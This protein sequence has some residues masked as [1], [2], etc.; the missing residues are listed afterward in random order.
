M[1]DSSWMPPAPDGVGST[2]DGGAPRL[3]TPTPVPPPPIADAPVAMSEPLPTPVLP[4]PAMPTPAPTGSPWS[5]TA[6]HVG[7]GSDSSSAGD[8]IPTISVEPP[9]KP[10]R[11]KVLVGGAVVAVLAVGTAGIFAV[12][13]IS[14]GAEGG[15]ATPDE[16]GAAL[17]TAFENEDAL[18]VI[19][20]L[21]PGERDLLRQPAIDLVG[22]LTRL[23]VLSPE[24]DLAGIAG[25]DVVLENE[26]VDIE[27][28]N[29]DDIVNV[30]MIA[31]AT[32]TL[33]GAAIPVGALVTDNMDADDVAEMRD[34]SETEES[35][36]DFEMTAVQ[37]DGRWYF[38]L[39]HTVAEVAR[40]ELGPDTLIP[41]E[42]IG[43]MGADTP[44][45]AME[46]MFDSIEALDVELLIQTLNPGE[47]AAL[48][49]Y[50]PL[51]LDDAEAALAEVPLDWQI[52]TREFRVEGDG[53]RR[54]V[55]V[56]AIGIDG[57]IDGDTFSVAV[58]GDCVTATMA[59]E[60]F[61][62]CA[63]DATAGNAE[64][65]DEMLADAP[66]VRAF[67][68]ALT[69]AFSDVEPL[70]LELREYDGG[71]YV[72]PVSTM[73]EAVL[74]VLRALDRAEIDNLI[75]LGEAAFSEGT[76]MVFG[77]LGIGDAGSFDDMVADDLSG[78]WSEFDDLSQD[79]TMLDDLSGEMT[80]A[81]TTAS[82]AWE[83]CYDETD[84]TT[85]IGCFQTYV[86]SG[87]IEPTF[88][89]IEL[90]FPECGY[91]DV[92]WTGAVYQMT[93]AEFIAAAE[94]ARPCFLALVE[95]GT[96]SEFEL[97]NEIAH[98]ECFE[99]RNWYT[100]FDDTAYDDRYYAC[101]DAALQ[102]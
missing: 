5:Q 89:P 74:G 57:T 9:A 85:A 65:L 66:S 18:G 99:G 90:R 73:S 78:D 7:S 69:A 10:K 88:V 42:G 31:D 13:G 102:D 97:P 60:T 91:A 47:A 20:V 43:A 44:E 38:S 56:D 53:A 82:A 80:P 64:M 21:L 6:P 15:A 2:N 51:F 40:A 3:P 61:D 30:Q 28:T 98:L 39:F 76:D 49:R 34:A 86:D 41:V 8:E 23:E 29:V 19:D 36:L 75:D 94:A 58:D 63:T 79:G 87:E 55:F 68:D 62:Q 81:S 22:E 95:A 4:A 92:R 1:D 84:P 33:D 50:A 83:A 70:G 101:I 32:V 77:D 67:F 45:G 72:S 16:L 54:T 100:T 27:P 96:V 93:D 26:V 59:G 52:T 25:F 17:M 37:Q 46:Q 48:Q 24:A 11:S 71:W 12:S 14:G 35:E